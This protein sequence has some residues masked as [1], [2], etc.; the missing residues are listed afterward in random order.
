MDKTP[1]TK[2]GEKKLQEELRNLKLERPKII[3]A[4]AEAR[5]HGDLKENAEYHAA[6]E[7]QGMNEARIKDI[8]FKLG[9]SEIIDNKK[10]TK[11]EVIFGCTV[12]LLNIDE[13]TKLKYQLVGEDEADLEKNKISFNSPIGKGLMNKSIGDII[14]ISVPKG[15][16]NLKIVNIN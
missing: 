7:Q 13:N 2:D 1:L 5:E 14:K 12:E 16:L 9:N 10:E 11:N 8:E 3:K 4:I 6:R 15:D